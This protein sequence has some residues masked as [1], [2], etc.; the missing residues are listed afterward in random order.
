M[1]IFH[2]ISIAIVVAVAVA[3]AGWFLGR[4]SVK[5]ENLPSIKKSGIAAAEINAVVTKVIDGDTVVVAGGDHLRLL[6]IDT[7]EKDYPCYDAARLRLEELV[8]GKEVI[9]E[10]DNDDTDQYGRKLRYIFLD[11]Q[12]INEKLV[13]EG[14]AVARFYPENQKYK[15][16]I[17]AAEAAAMKNKTGCKWGG[18]EKLKAAAGA[19]D[20]YPREAEEDGPE[21][22][23]EERLEEG[24]RYPAGGRSD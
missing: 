2:K 22:G 13:A 24:D 20:E 17:T 9:L 15:A 18:A 10:S 7:D 11:G 5:I 21:P 6:G 23:L 16:E 19:N 3:A 14:L 8:L 4:V 12:N 1:K